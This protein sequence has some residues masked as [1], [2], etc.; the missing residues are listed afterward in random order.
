MAQLLR[1]IKRALLNSDPSFC[2]MYADEESRTAAAEYL[3]LVRRHLRERFGN[4]L[5]TILDAGCQA[6]RLLIPLAQDGHRLIGID[7]SGFALHRARQHAKDHR[8]SVLVHRGNIAHLRRWV[9]PLSLDAV[10]CTE[11]LYL[12]RN[13]QE[14]LRLLADSV[15]PGGLLFVSHRPAMYYVVCALRRGQPDQAI[16]VAHRSEGATP[17]GAYF[18][19]QTPEQL[20]ALYHRQGLATLGCYPIHEDRVQ[21]DPAI[22][23]DNALRD[24]LDSA[25]ENG[26]TLRVP[27]YLLIAAQKPQDASPLL[28]P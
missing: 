24:L 16:S 17:E 8:L 25:R 10:I 1:K 9:S 6:G 2:D 3:D 7:T 4:Q 20:A 5:L 12:C 22:I 18:N 15:K 23:Q 26:T 19:W 27:S 21:L 14:L 28:H 11:V 13:H